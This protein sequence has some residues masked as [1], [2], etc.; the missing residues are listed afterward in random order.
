MAL[1]VMGDLR[2]RLEEFLVSVPVNVSVPKDRPSYLVTVTR[3]GGR[4]L[5]A[6]QDRSGIGLYCFA[7]TEQEA[8]E[9]A[10]K[11]A[12]FFETLKF[13]NGYERVRQEAM[14]SAADP[15]TRE[16]RWYLSYTITTHE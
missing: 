12:N 5:N 9:L 15:D 10:N 11:V 7:P 8:W 13:S 16:P 1:N 6:L 4:R 2:E 14:F 3:E